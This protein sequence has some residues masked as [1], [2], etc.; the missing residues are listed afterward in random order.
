MK[1]S[2]IKWGDQEDAHK[3]LCKITLTWMPLKTQFHVEFKKN[4]TTEI[5]AYVRA[6]DTRKPKGKIWVRVRE[7]FKFPLTKKQMIKGEHFVNAA[8][9]VYKTLM[10]H[11]IDENFTFLGERIW[12]PHTRSG[13][14]KLKGELFIAP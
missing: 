11:E 4:G 7:V 2:N 6:N 14:K 1:I 10:I 5:S 12:D 13:R 9:Y 3:T 8:R